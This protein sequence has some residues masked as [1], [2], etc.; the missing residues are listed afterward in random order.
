MQTNYLD[1][2]Q[3]LTILNTSFF[4]VANSNLTLANIY[5]NQQNIQKLIFF[6]L[7]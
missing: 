2:N 4:L 7:T 3:M 6:N 1:S 5:I